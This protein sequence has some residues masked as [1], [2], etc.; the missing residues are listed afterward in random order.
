M[1][2]YSERDVERLVYCVVAT[3]THRAVLPGNS[4]GGKTA[5]KFCNSALQILRALFHNKHSISYEFSSYRSSR[6]PPLHM[7]YSQSQSI[8]RPGNTSVHRA[9]PPN[10]QRL[11]FADCS[12]RKNLQSCEPHSNQHHASIEYEIRG[13][14]AAP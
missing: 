7:Y 8:T 3:A 9:K 12:T 13:C 10:H 6:R 2:P 1:M 11:F 4:V 14:R 5:E